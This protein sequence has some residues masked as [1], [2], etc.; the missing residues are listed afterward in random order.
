MMDMVQT[1]AVATANAVLPGS[2]AI[3]NNAFELGKICAEIAELLA[4]M[5]D[6]ASSINTQ[7]ANIE[8]DVA[9]FRWVLEVLGR[10]QHKNKLTTELQKL[11]TRFETEVKEYDRVMKKFLEQNILKQLV[12]HNDLDAVSAS[13]KET[14]GQLVQCVTTE[15]AINGSVTYG[16]ID[17]SEER[18]NRYM[19]FIDSPE[20]MNAMSDADNQKEILA[21]IACMSRRNEAMMQSPLETNDLVLNVMKEKL[22]A[23]SSRA[24]QDDVKNLPDWYITEDEVEIDMSTIIGFG[25]D[26]KIYKGVLEDGTPVAVKVFN[27]NVK[28]SD[29]SKTKFFNTMKLWVRKITSTDVSTLVSLTSSEDIDVLH[30]L[31]VDSSGNAYVSRLSEFDVV[32]ITPNGTITTFVNASTVPIPMGITIDSSDNIYLTDMHR[33]LKFTSTGEMSVVAGSGE[34]GFVNGIGEAARFSTPWALTIGS[35][36]NLYVAES[37]NNCIRKIDLA[38]TEVTTYA[39]ICETSGSTDGLAANATFENIHAIAAAANNVF[40]VTDGPQ[41]QRLRKIY[42]I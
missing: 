37:V 15:C 32:K 18:A 7:S 26:A 21:I 39:G 22:W 9:Y 16:H 41:G 10:V 29:E 28:R 13:V 34:K 27:A 23:S 20:V 35:D 25:G 30:G 42:T 3:V 31:A 17:Q 6:T 19:K 36:G 1:A 33:V 11:I 4:G 24:V 40:Y 2:G 8:K 5:Q 38:T 14:A 12:F